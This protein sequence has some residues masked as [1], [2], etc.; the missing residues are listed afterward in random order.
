MAACL[1]LAG[2][3]LGCVSTTIRSNEGEFVMSDA[4]EACTLVIESDPPAGKAP[5]WME[6][7]VTGDDGNCLV[8]VYSGHTNGCP[9][10][11]NPTFR[12]PPVAVRQ[13]DSLATGT[14][15]VVVKASGD[16][17]CS[18]IDVHWSVSD[19]TKVSSRVV[20]A[21]VLTFCAFSPLLFIFSPIGTL[22]VAFR[23]RGRARLPRSLELNAFILR[24]WRHF[25]FFLYAI[26]ILIGI[27]AGVLAP[28]GFGAAV[29]VI[30]VMGGAQA[31][32][33]LI[34]RRQDDEYFMDLAYLWAPLKALEPGWVESQGTLVWPSFEITSAIVTWISVAF[35]PGDW[36]DN[37]SVAMVFAAII[38]TIGGILIVYVAYQ[39]RLRA[40][41]ARDLNALVRSNTTLRAGFIAAFSYIGDMIALAAVSIASLN[42]P[43]PA[44][45]FFNA[46]KAFMFNQIRGLHISILYAWR[47][48]CKHFWSSDLDSYIGNTELSRV[49]CTANEEEP[50]DVAQ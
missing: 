47:M 45:L 39:D 42:C 28:H 27:P 25:F 33:F 2:V 35:T 32:S 3:A 38:E 30:L 29:A 10:T 49:T 31:V 4:L 34:Y 14:V 5:K 9:L 20:M 26:C 19:D 23:H 44:I 24:P 13:G 36:S 15:R 41:K 12:Q 18:Q 16:V 21:L 17:P 11:K 6:V 48:T 22:F 7:N 46:T 50:M 43:L 8:A 40:F 1:V 37:N